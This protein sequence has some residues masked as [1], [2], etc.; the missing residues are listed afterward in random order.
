[1]LLH[2]GQLVSALREASRYQGYLEPQAPPML[3]YSVYKAVDLRDA[4]PAPDYPYRNST[5]YPRDN[6]LRGAWGFDYGQ[7]F[8]QEF[9]RLYGIP[10]KDGHAMDLCELVNEG[11]V[12]EVW[13]YGDADVPGEV[14]AAEILEMKRVYDAERRLLPGAPAFDFCAGNGCFDPDDREVLPGH[15]VRS[16]RI[17]WINQ[18]RGIGCAMENIGHGLEQ[19]GLRGVIPYLSAY[20][21]SFADLNLNT[22]YGTPFE[23]WYACGAG[24]ECVTFTSES[25]VTY[26]TGF[27][28]GAIPDY[29]PAC[30]NVHFPP[31]GRRHYDLESPYTA[32]STCEHFRFGDGALGADQAVPF[33]TSKFS[34]YSAIAGDCM[35]PWL[36]FWMQSIPG[37]ANRSRDLDGQP[38]LAWWPFLFY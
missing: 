4:A 30:G 7:L 13:V 12:H 36:V 16:L 24:T 22:R 26:D 14:N 31:N 18:S 33:A 20:F 10:A 2:L 6:P 27:L 19:T 32:L 28:Q 21:R 15:C 9:A 3:N 8:S 38:M 37:F 11:I 1:M 5:L 17:M 25:S 34:D 23:S 35:G 29:V